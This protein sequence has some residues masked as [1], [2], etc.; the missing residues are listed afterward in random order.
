MLIIGFILNENAST[1]NLNADETQD[2]LASPQLLI[3]LDEL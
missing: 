1:Q 2:T 3:F